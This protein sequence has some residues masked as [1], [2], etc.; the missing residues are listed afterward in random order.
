M[1]GIDAFTKLMLH[2]DGAG[3]ST[4]FPDSSSGAHTITAN[5]DAQVDTAQSKFGGAS[6]LLDGSG[7]YLSS[8]DDADY[9]LG[10]SDFTLECWVRFNTLPG[11]GTE[12]ALLSKY[13]ISG[14]QR[15][16]RLTY[17]GGT[18]LRFIYSTDGTTT[19]GADKSWSP[20]TGTWYH[21]ALVR[22]GNTL[23][24]FID[25]TSIGTA[26]ISGAIFDGT[27]ALQ[28]GA[29]NSGAFLNG[30]VDEVRISVGVARWTAN[31]TPPAVPYS[32]FS[33]GGLALLGVGV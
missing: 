10:S 5:G 11:S 2:C 20:S 31:F 32:A 16:W 24:Y 12:V 15:S 28:I 21:V 4:S 8:A 27:A 13:T 26:A 18:G 23:I 29:Y 17:V 22:S 30:W 19:G 9:E 6:L 7:D 3:G 33:P 1:A 14:N 25:G